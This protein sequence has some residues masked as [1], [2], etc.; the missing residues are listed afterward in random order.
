MRSNRLILWTAAFLCTAVASAYADTTDVTHEA[1]VLVAKAGDHCADDPSCF[2]RYHPAIKPVA[3]VQPGQLVVLETRDA[4]DSN[5]N[6]QSTA[7]DV[8]ALDLNLERSAA[9]SLL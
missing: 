1:P 9:M 6:L 2:N 8:T 3:R 4:F 7:E 5:L